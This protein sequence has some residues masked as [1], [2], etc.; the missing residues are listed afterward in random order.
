MSN[1]S[2]DRYQQDTARHW[3]GA[4]HFPAQPAYHEARNARGAEPALT[5][6][7]L[8]QLPDGAST[9]RGLTAR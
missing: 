4:G 1:L 7:E 9:R 6:T 8:N 3:R 5:W 2:E